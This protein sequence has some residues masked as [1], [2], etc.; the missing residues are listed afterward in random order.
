MKLK[1]YGYW[2]SSAS[3]RVRWAL[4]LK[5][6]DYDY[7]P[8]NILKGEHQAPEHRIRVPLGTLP[9]L[10]LAP[11]NFLSQSMAILFY[12]DETFPEVTSLF[13]SPL[14]QRYKILEL[15]ELINADTAPLQTPRAQKAFSG[16]PALRAKD[17]VENGLRAFTSLLQKGRMAGR[18]HFCLGDAVTA[19]DLFLVPQVY[20]AGRFGVDLKR[21]F[22]ILQEI[23]ENCLATDEC[24]TAS[25]ERQIDSVNPPS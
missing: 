24:A 19:A 9:V 22:P 15:C 2:R 17:F 16:D 13:G 25:P 8:V 3:W 10:E 20:N 14:D 11:G 6:V 4:A 1:L 18:N 7:M 23:Y 12:I 21:E 5:K